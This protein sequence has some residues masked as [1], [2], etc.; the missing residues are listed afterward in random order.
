MLLKRQKETCI[1][2]LF[3]QLRARLAMQAIF[4]VF[5]VDQYEHL[6]NSK[7]ADAIH[8]VLHVARPTSCSCFCVSPQATM[9]A[10]T[11]ECK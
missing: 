8:G 7:Q 2:R 5:K 4:A 11:H 6:R 3:V 1:L 10:P 9:H